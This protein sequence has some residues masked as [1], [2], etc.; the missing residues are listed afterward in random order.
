MQPISIF[1]F[2]RDLRLEDNVALFH[3]LQSKYAVLP[4]FIFDEEILDDLKEDKSTAILDAR[5][6]FIYDQLKNIKKQL[7]QY[8]SDIKIFYGSVYDVWHK[9]IKENNVHAVY[10]NHDYEPYA[11]K[12]D[13]KLQEFFTKN[14]IETYSY[15]DHVIF[16]KNEIIKDNNT[17]YL[18]YTPYSKKWKSTLNDTYIQAF[19]SEQYLK[20]LLQTNQQSELFSLNEIGFEHKNLDFPTSN[21]E[22]ALITNYSET[23]DIPSIQ[24]TSRLGVHL[25]FG[26]ISIR[27]LVSRCL[28]LQA[29]KYLN[30]LIWREFYI[31]ILYHFSNV[32]EQSFKPEYDKIEWRNNHAEFDAWCNGMTGYPIVDAGMRELNATG[33]MHNR[34][35]MIVASFLCKH[36]LIDWRWGE[37]YFAKKLLDFELASNNGSWQWCAGTGVDA[38]PYFRLFNPTLQTEKFDSKLIYIKKWIPEL[39]TMSYPLPIVQH[40]FARNRCLN[41]YKKALEKV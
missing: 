11:I 16:E 14:N 12:R 24:G 23:R 38:S 37:A 6:I 3:A 20:N 26:T 40:E 18:V 34:V 25:R 7:A 32:I 17:P 30:E 29:E 4:I 31:H 9:I 28:E 8:N 10:F 33:Y 19:P 39:E 27:K 35:R 13:E 5:V 36:L 2:R 22:D 41:I 21:V 1:W 15:K